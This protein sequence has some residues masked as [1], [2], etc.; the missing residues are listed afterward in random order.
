M[1]IV[2]DN[3]KAVVEP[4]P[5]KVFL[6]KL[7][8]LPPLPP[9]AEDAKVILSPEALV[10][11]VILLP[12]TKVRV[13]VAESATTSSCPDTD[14]VLNASPTEPPPVTLKSNVPSESS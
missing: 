2:V 3:V 13:S 12:A 11:I 8:L 1:V 14:I 5:A 9:L 10:V 7:E 6:A 4:S